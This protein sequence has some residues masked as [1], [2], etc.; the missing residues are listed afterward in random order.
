METFT[1]EQITKIIENFE[2]AAFDNPKAC[3]VSATSEAFERVKDY[4]KPLNKEVA[5]VC[6]CVDPIPELTDDLKL[7]THCLCGGL[8]PEQR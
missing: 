2:Q 8:M 5:T 4:F 6:S 3:F 7:G 1:R